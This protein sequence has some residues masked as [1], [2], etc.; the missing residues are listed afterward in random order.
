MGRHSH[1]ARWLEQELN[2]FGISDILGQLEA[3]SSLRCFL[4]LLGSFH[5]FLVGFVMMRTL[6][7]SMETTKETG[8]VG[9]RY[10]K[11]PLLQ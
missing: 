7:V 1:R 3:I 5:K 11:A 8:K 4:H 10:L 6:D 2:L 9:D